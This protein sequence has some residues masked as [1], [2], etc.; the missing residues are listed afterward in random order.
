MHGFT[1]GRKIRLPLLAFAESRK[2]NNKR[3]KPPNELCSA[4][5]QNIDSETKQPINDI[6]K[7]ECVINFIEYT[8]NMHLAKT[9]DAN[10]AHENERK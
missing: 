5:K 7:T 8:S 2:N 9:S 1:G 4:Q 10:Q 6:W 3:T